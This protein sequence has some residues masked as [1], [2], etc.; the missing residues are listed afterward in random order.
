LFGGTKTIS[1]TNSDGSPKPTKTNTN[2]IKTLPEVVKNEMIRI[3]GGEMKMG[4][5]DGQLQERP[6]HRVDVA[7]FWMDKTEVTNAEYYEFVKDS[8][9]DST[10]ANWERGKPM[11]SDLKM[12]VRFVSHNDAID[13]AAWRSNRDNLT[14]RLPT[15]QEW[16]FAA[17]NGSQNNL[18]PWGDDYKSECAVLDQQTNE[19][20]QV[21]SSDCGTNKWGVH[22]LIGN[23]FEWTSSEAGLYPGND[24]QVQKTSERHFMIR[25]GASNYKSTGPA[26]ITSTFRTPIAGTKKDA[27]LGFR[28]VRSG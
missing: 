26:A 25:G 20:K 17:R 9:H 4:R 13:F 2:D 23:V 19:P 3:P 12:P 24:G 22:D 18:Y 16:E 28:L 21:G 15:E 27:G 8:G 10:P 14:Y 5:N 7:G 11:E 1:D 6:E